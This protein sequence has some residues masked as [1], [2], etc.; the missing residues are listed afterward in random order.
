MPAIRQHPSVTDLHYASASG[1]LGSLLLASQAD[2][3]CCVL[4]GDA[5][6]TLLADLQRRFPQARLQPGDERCQQRASALAADPLLQPDWPLTLAGTPFQQR[7]WQALR[8]IPPGQTCS[9]RE[10]A[11]AIDQ[12]SAS[13]AVA[14]AC[15]A[16]PLAL[17]VPC[18][19]VI[20]RDGVLAGYRWGIERKQWLLAQEAIR[21]AGPRAPAAGRD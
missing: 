19:R 15:A 2:G 12:P 3:I 21:A 10:L 11:A 16:N 13:R 4:L 20:R 1:P 14:A 5:L 9:Y 7:V 8:Q 18:H 6:P 17:L